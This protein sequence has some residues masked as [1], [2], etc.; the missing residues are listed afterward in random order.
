MLQIMKERT[1]DYDSFV[2]TVRDVVKERMGDGFD[3]RIYK[4]IKN[5]SLELDSLVILKEGRGIAPNIY[6]KPYYES[7]LEGTSVD[8]IVERLCNIYNHCSMPLVQEDF[9]YTLKE[10]KPYIFYRT[11][12]F[13]RNR[14][15]LKDIPHIRYLDLAITFH[16]LVQSDEEGIG[17]IRITNGHLKQWGITLGDLKKLADINTAR[18]FPAAIVKME[19]VLR[20]MFKNGLT[21]D[22][23]SD[24]TKELEIML[25]DK[26]VT[27]KQNDMYVLS[28]QKGI[29]G[30]SCILYEDILQNFARKINSDFYILPSSIHEVLLVP[31][32]K[33]MKKEDLAAMVRE[34]NV[35]QVADEEVLSDNVYF[36]SRESNKVLLNP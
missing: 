35:T 9:T 8:V 11:V 13:D 3:I 29:S 27:G 14:K 34:I 5:N 2:S 24:F 23:D 18:L 4:V 31:E 20:G 28:N 32:T 17:T 25:T 7:Y 6:F 1:L 36:F 30:S 15:L 22:L 33:N 12:S 19:E 21:D 10:M 26:G 16:C